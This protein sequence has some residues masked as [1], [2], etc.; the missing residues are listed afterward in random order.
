MPETPCKGIGQEGKNVLRQT[1]RVLGFHE[2]ENGCV[3]TKPSAEFI[4][5]WFAAVEFYQSMLSPAPPYLPPVQARNS[6]ELWTG[7]VSIMVYADSP[8]M[9]AKHLHLGRLDRRL[10]LA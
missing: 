5:Q 3:K 1:V 2:P 4:E 6:P 8:C 7:P 9:P 10:A